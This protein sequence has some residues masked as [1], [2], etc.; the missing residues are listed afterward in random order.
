MTQAQRNLAMGVLYLIFAILFF[1][2]TYHFSGYELEVIPHDVGDTFLPRILLVALALQ[3]I[4]LICFS[5]RDHFK[6]H[7]DSTEPKAFFQVRPLVMFGAFL[8]YVYLAT[9]FGY[10]ISTLAFMVLGFYL[11]DVRSLWPIIFIPPAITLASYYLF[12]I[13]LNVYLPSG[14]LF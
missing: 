6:S 14:N 13:L 1:V 12:G 8:A 2:L 9:L 10:I 5:L 4:S 11:L 7:D 3:A